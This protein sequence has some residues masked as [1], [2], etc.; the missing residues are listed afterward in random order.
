MG[1]MANTQLVAGLGQPTFIEFPYDP[2]QWDLDRRDYIMAEPLVA[3]RDG[4]LNL[5]N[6]PGM[7][8][9]VDEARLAKTLIG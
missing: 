5:S 2:P 3:D 6:A 7:G 4:W 1:V 8:Y 9:A